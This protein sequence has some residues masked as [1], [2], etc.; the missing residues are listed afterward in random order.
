M[1]ELLAARNEL[2]RRAPDECF[3]SLD[4]LHR[5]CREERASST[6]RWQLPH[7][8]LPHVADGELA[9][10]LED[11]PECRLNDWSFSQVCRMAGVA[12]ET[13]NR[14]SPATAS[15]ALGETMPGGAKPLQ[16]LRTRHLLR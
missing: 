3:A 2:F 15:L 13:L 9:L 6:D 11:A 7:T 1:A 10:A 12:K 14:L 5:H 8:L 4:E 16:L